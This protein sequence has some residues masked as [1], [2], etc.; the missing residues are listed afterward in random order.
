MRVNYKKVAMPSIDNVTELI[1][2][3]EATMEGRRKRLIL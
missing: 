2:I 1:Q 3:N